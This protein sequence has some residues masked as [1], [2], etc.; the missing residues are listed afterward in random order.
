MYIMSADVKES[1]EKT[2][3]RAEQ[4]INP[5]TGRKVKPSHMLQKN[6]KRKRETVA[7]AVVEAKD[8]EESQD[9]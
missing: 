2:A 1:D 9:L 8:L 3:L 6:K 7:G 4:L 5:T